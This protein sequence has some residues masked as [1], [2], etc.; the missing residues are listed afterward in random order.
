MDKGIEAL[1]AH[2]KW[3]IKDAAQD[4]HNMIGVK[5]DELA[6][7]IAALEQAQQELIKPLA[8]GELIH[9]LENQTGEKWIREV[10]HNGMMQ[11]SNELA[12]MKQTVSRLRGERDTMLRDRLNNME[13]RPLCVKSN[14]AMR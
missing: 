9:R 1:I 12:E 13:S 6:E 2:M 7:L 14:D 4:G 5:S 3:R 8:I 10:D 11:L